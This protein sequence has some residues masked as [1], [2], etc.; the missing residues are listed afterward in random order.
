MNMFSRVR[1]LREENDKNQEFMAKYLNVTQAT[2]SRYENGQIDI[3][4]YICIRLA[5]FYGVSVDYLLGRTNV[6]KPYP[7]G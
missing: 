6:A 5:D 3:P 7:R 2:Y 4:I 1:E